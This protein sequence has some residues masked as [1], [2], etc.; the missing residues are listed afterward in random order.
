LEKYSLSGTEVD[1][2]EL[3]PTIDKC[4]Y[5]NIKV[6]P[7]EIVYEVTTWENALPFGIAIADI[8][9]SEPH[10]HKVTAETYTVVQGNLEVSLNGEEHVLHP[11]DVIKI[12]PNVIHSARSLSGTPAR[13]AVTTIPEFSHEDYYVV[14]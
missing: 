10:F 1:V 13:I 9:R 8:Q 12:P 6:N 7:A 2:K 4:L 3:E 14:E 5:Q 11:S